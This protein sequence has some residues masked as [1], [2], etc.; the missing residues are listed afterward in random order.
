M[1]SPNKKNTLERS[2]APTF[3]SLVDRVIETN[4]VQAKAI[5]NWLSEVE[6]DFWRFA[7][8]GARVISETATNFGHDI[9]EVADA[10]NGMCREM[11][12]EQ[13]KFAR[14]GRYSAASANDAYEAVYSSV[15]T[16]QRYMYGLALSQ[17]LWANHYKMYRF[18]MNWI[19]RLPS[20]SSYLEVGAGHGLNLLYALQKWPDAGARVVDISET[21]V[22]IC[23]RI[24]SQ[25]VPDADCEFIVAD[26]NIYSG[27]PAE[28]LVIG[29]VLEH[30]D[31][32]LAIL[33][34]LRKLLSD[35]GCL[36]LTTCARCPAVDHIYLYQ[37]VEHI[38][39]HIEQA[40]FDIVDRLVLPIQNAPRARDGDTR[41]GLN[42]SAVC[43]KRATP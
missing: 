22:D 16:M 21:S 43:K 20:A 17:F 1:S 5:G 11:L 42:Y 9:N 28:R 35:N 29:E 39:S 27:T 7:E 15:D 18:F 24:V 41:P 13:M 23:R 3:F 10:Y 32:P 31:D 6:P 19:D 30:V 12:V 14:T 38:E 36:L 2:T 40:G 37:D 25:F 33:N 26:I 34:S 4:P 8:D